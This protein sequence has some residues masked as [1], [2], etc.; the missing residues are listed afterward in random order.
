MK[1]Q[2]YMEKTPE[3]IRL[4]RRSSTED[5]I[6]A[7]AFLRRADLFLR[8]EIFSVFLKGG[9]IERHIRLRIKDMDQVPVLR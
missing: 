3:N 7:G 9:A 2:Q 5:C 1:T 6:S 4:R 8:W